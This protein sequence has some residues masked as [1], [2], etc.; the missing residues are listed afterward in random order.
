MN[1]LFKLLCLLGLHKFK[2]VWT[3]YYPFVNVEQHKC[4][5]CNVYTYKE[6]G[7]NNTP[8]NGKVW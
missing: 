2:Y 7:K 8:K 5:F 3:C 4:M 1:T 6:T